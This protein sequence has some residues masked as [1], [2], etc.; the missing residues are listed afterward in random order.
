MNIIHQVSCYVYNALSKPWKNLHCCPYVRLPYHLAMQPFHQSH[1]PCASWNKKETTQHIAKIRLRKAKLHT[2]KFASTTANKW[3]L[4]STQPKQQLITFYWNWVMGKHEAHCLPLMFL[5]IHPSTFPSHHVSCL[6]FH[7]SPCSHFVTGTGQRCRV[8]KDQ[9]DLFPRLH[10]LI[11]Q[12][13]P[14]TPLPESASKLYDRATAP[15]RSSDNF[16]G[17]GILRGQRDGALWPYSRFSRH[18]AL[19]F[20]PSSSSIVLTRLSGPRS[21]P[22]TSQKI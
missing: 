6:S 13:M 14:K 9:S 21:R 16:W 20:L 3:K 19:L 2:H 8:G 11:A 7:F 12:S 15:R 10:C 1:S 5:L 18:D 22:T 4:Q 17:Y